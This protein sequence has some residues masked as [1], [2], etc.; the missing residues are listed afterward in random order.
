MLLGG[1]AGHTNKQLGFHGLE[2]TAS[3]FIAI[4]RILTVRARHL[5]LV[6]GTHAHM[7]SS[8][9]DDFLFAVSEYSVWL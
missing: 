1:V 4:L 2:A 8:E 9:W 6:Q 5:F 3:D 7:A